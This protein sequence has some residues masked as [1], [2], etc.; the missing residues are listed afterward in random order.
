[1]KIKVKEKFE[2]TFFNPATRQF[3]GGSW[4]ARV[5]VRGNINISDLKLIQNA[6]DEFDHSTIMP[7]EFVTLEEIKKI[8]QRYSV[9]RDAN[10]KTELFIGVSKI[11]LNKVVESNS[12][13]ASRIEKLEFWRDNNDVEIVIFRADIDESGIKIVEHEA[14]D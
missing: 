5:T 4:H 9:F 11:I 14:R 3:E 6:V 8:N 2:A 1:M 12:A 10:D 13:L 7:A